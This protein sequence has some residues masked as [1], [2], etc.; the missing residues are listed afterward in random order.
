MDEGWYGKFDL[1]DRDTLGQGRRTL[2][3]LVSDS[4]CMFLWPHVSNFMLQASAELGREEPNPQNSQ[5]QWKYCLEQLALA[6]WWWVMVM[7]ANL[8]PEG[9]LLVLR[10]AG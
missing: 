7:P 5:S 4:S 9:G 8:G 3:N 10:Q 2:I 6:V 1:R